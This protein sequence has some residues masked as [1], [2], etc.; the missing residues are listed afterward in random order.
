MSICVR[1]YHVKLR[2]RP[3]QEC[4]FHSRANRDEWIRSSAYRLVSL[5]HLPEVA[6]HLLWLLWMVMV[7]VLDL[8][9]QYTFARNGPSAERVQLPL[10]LR[11]RLLIS[12]LRSYI[13]LSHRSIQYYTPLHLLRGAIFAYPRSPGCP[14]PETALECAGCPR[15]AQPG[16]LSAPTVQSHAY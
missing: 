1:I 3:P 13:V 16:L 6:V 14:T 15:T 8:L 4:V 2:S 9:L 11:S 12:P 10:S 7:V 5:E